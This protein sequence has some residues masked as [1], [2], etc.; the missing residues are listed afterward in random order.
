MSPKELG[1]PGAKLADGE[2]VIPLRSASQNSRS[3]IEFGGF[4][5]ATGL[6]VP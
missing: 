2:D 5:G 6:R 3:G 4:A 1:A